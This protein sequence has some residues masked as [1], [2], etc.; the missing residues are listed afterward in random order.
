[1]ASTAV[2]E[3]R[4]SGGGKLSR[5]ETVTVR[6][7][8]KLR[9]LAELASRRQRRTLSS[10]VEWALEDILS[11]VELHPA[12]DISVADE[13]NELWDV[14]EAD[15]F[16]KLA[17]KH[18]E[19]L[20]HEEQIRWKLIRENGWLWR[21]GYS[22]PDKT[23]A[24]TIREGGLVMDRLRES[25]DAFCEVAEGGDPDLLPGWPKKQA[26]SSAPP[27]KA[28]SAPPAKPSSGFDDMDDDIPF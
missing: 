3:K 15:R 7:D 19:L 13:A 20:T 26:A 1:M 4:K 24:W 18:P 12:K 10:F 22:G 11:R 23:W 17:F 8:P 21:G 5:S 2:S 9:Y 14:D 6:L 27:P 16:A 25:W 28:P